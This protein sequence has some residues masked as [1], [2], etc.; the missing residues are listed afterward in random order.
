MQWVSETMHHVL[1]SHWLPDDSVLIGLS[2]DTLKVA[3]ERG[4]SS[5]GL[6]DDIERQTRAAI[7]EIRLF[8]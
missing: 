8:D 6:Y 5:D 2:L 4:A 7:A 1:A 3:Q